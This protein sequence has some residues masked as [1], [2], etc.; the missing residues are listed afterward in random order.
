MAKKKLSVGISLMEN[1]KDII[2]WLNMMREENQKVRTWVQAIL[3][4]EL[5]G[6]PLD[7]GGVYVPPKA[8]PKAKSSNI[9]FGDDTTASKPKVKKASWEVK[10]DSG[11]FVV[12]SMLVIV[13]S[14]P[15][16]LEAL[17]RAN[18][19]KTSTYI[20]AVLRKHIRKL[21]APPNEPPEDVNVED[22]FV[23]YE[24]HFKKQESAP[25]PVVQPAQTVFA[26]PVIIPAYT[27]V[28]G[29]QMV[30]PAVM[31]PI[32]PAV[33]SAN[34]TEKAREPDKVKRSAV[35]Q[36]VQKPVEKKKKNPLL[37]YIS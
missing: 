26:Q 19:S 5:A 24:D 17:E 30:Q 3:L 16:I 32:Q 10:G 37:D 12:G 1:D 21:D 27:P 20:K 15:V 13:I 7:A 23:L 2:A 18:R 8:K 36:A 14:R 33:M 25:A 22:L 11:E 6:I 34:E 4:A 29:Q 28:N 31:P 35:K 9:L